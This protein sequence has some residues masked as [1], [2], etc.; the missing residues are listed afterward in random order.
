M[1]DRNSAFDRLRRANPEPTR[2]IEDKPS[3]H[4]MLVAAQRRPSPEPPRPWRRGL[5]VAAAAAIVVVLVTV[6]ILLFL[7]AGDEEAPVVTEPPTPPRM[8]STHGSEPAG[9]RGT[10]RPRAS[11]AQSGRRRIAVTM[12][13]TNMTAMAT[14]MTRSKSRNPP[15]QT[16]PSPMSECPMPQMILAWWS[17]SPKSYRPAPATPHAETIAPPVMTVQHSR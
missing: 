17:G 4:E 1:S 7:N 16:R 8:P 9:M 11:A 2:P 15:T 6:P 3:A 5:M 10:N 13:V 14:A 12:T